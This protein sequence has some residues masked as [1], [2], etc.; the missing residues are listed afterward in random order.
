MARKRDSIEMSEERG[1]FRCSLQST[2]NHKLRTTPPVSSNGLSD[3]DGHMAELLSR[4]GIRDSIHPIFAPHRFL[5]AGNMY[6][7][8]IVSSNPGKYYADIL[9]VLQAASLILTHKSQLPF[10]HGMITAA[11]EE[12][13]LAS[14]EV[15]FH[16]KTHLNQDEV[17]E[18]RAFLV[19]LA[20]TICFAPDYGD[21]VEDDSDDDDEGMQDVQTGQ[22]T[23]NDQDQDDGVDG[24][25]EEDFDEAITSTVYIKDLGPDDVPKGIKPGRSTSGDFFLAIIVGS[26]YLPGKAARDAQDPLQMQRAYFKLLE[27][28]LHE[29]AHAAVTFLNDTG[30]D[31]YFR[32]EAV[33]ETGFAYINYLFGGIPNVEDSLAV[34][35]QWPARRHTVA[36][37]SEPEPLAVRGDIPKLIGSFHVLDAEI[38]KY[39]A[40][41]FWRQC[42]W[43][44]DGSRSRRVLKPLLLN[45]CCETLPNLIN[46]PTKE[47]MYARLR[48]HG[49]IDRVLWLEVSKRYKLTQTT[50]IRAIEE[51]W[52]HPKIAAR[53]RAGRMSLDNEQD[54]AIVRHYCFQRRR[55]IP[56]VIP[57]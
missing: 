15:T 38:A 42:N 3:L 44:T 4:V 10:W 32:Q 27:L 46:Q 52:L 35:S 21:A 54:Q 39:F 9:P 47:G 17:E 49:A 51:S 37:D 1:N 23:Q 29:L 36:Y 43:T 24:N 12:K 16:A 45:R 6:D 48:G 19:E 50:S 11:N 33:K 26:R 7:R 25:D 40:A 2:S 8:S 18:T 30:E 14:E 41:A 56:E 34:V 20:D 5:Q 53:L 13:H 28:L 57:Q 55:R 22:D 31:R